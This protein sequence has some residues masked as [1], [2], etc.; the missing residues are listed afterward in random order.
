M[1]TP[2]AS[3]FPVTGIDV[4]AWQTGNVAQALGG[5]AF[6]FVRASV[7]ASRDPLFARHVAEVR[8]SGRLAFAYH[9]MV[10]PGPG[11]GTQAATFLR[12]AG[13]APLL[14]LDVE[15]SALRF[16]KV[17]AGIIH[18]I[19]ERDPLH[20]L[21]LLYGSEANWPGDLGQDAN[22]VA[23]Y[24]RQPRMPWAFW[25]NAGAPLDHDVFNGN[26]A[27]L[28]ALARVGT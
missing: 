17:A 6:A 15:S 4:S 25:Q 10:P 19:R 21:I 24:A 27:K 8:S 16:P 14:A 28:R 12:A 22:W 18:L 20:R 11:D 5:H 7:G 23:N 2:D 13:D 26:L 9:F 1:T 3:R